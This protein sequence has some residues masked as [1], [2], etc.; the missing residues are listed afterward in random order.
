MRGDSALRIRRIERNSFQAEPIRSECRHQTQKPTGW[1]DLDHR[2]HRLGDFPRGK[3]DE[4][5]LHRWNQVCHPQVL[6]D[7]F[8]VEKKRLINHEWTLIH[9]NEENQIR[10]YSCVLV[11]S[12]PYPC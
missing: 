4:R 6:T 7:V 10:V 11:V 2:A 5:F 3:I 8:F 1:I 12:N 9:T